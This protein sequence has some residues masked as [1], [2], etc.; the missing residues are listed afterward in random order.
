VIDDDRAREIASYW[1]SPS[2]HDDQ[3]T[4]LSHGMEVTDWPRLHQQ[5]NREY[6]QAELKRDPVAVEE[7]LALREWIEDIVPTLWERPV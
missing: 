5:V 6:V 2:P 3:I 1:H 7:L 4:R